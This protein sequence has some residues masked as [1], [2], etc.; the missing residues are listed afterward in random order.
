MSNG[1]V[2]VQVQMEDVCLIFGEGIELTLTVPAGTTV[3]QVPVLTDTDPT[4]T[5]AWLTGEHDQ[6]GRP[7]LRPRLQ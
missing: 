7:V 2:T 6:Q 5:T 3:I 1:P 4:L